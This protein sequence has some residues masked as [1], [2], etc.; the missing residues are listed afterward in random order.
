[1][2]APRSARVVVGPVVLVLISFCL[3]SRARRPSFRGR[4][5]SVLDRIEPRI[6]QGRLG[7]PTTDLEG[8]GRD[9]EEG[10]PASGSRGKTHKTPCLPR[11]FG[12][13]TPSFPPQPPPFL[14]HT[15]LHP[16]PGPPVA[17]QTS[18][19]L[20]FRDHARPRCQLLVCRRHFF[21]FK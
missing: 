19:P 13:T 9:Q 6:A 10:E 5:A 3:V 14:P 18:T 11:L 21:D 1:M 7:S 16:A 20:F 4:F 8:G 17:P 2:V 12:L 15:P